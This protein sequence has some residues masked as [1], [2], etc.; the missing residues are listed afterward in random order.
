LNPDGFRRKGQFPVEW[1]HGGAKSQVRLHTDYSGLSQRSSWGNQNISL[2]VVANL[3]EGAVSYH[4]IC[5]YSAGTRL[6]FSIKMIAAFGLRD[7]S[8]NRRQKTK[9]NERIEPG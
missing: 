4:E 1:K 5:S 7:S 3:A 2:I 6:A 9:R 8:Q